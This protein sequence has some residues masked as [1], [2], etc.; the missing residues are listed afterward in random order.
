MA[1]R[2]DEEIIE[3]QSPSGVQIAFEIYEDDWEVKIKVSIT[4]RCTD[5]FGFV[6]LF[7]VSFFV[8]ITKRCTDCFLM[9]FAG[10]GFGAFQSPSGVQI[11]FKPIIPSAYTHPFQSPNGVQI[12]FA[13]VVEETPKI[14][15]SITKRCTD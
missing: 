9:I 1:Y 11:D 5:C 15:V 8:S 13:V 6:L 14:T 10:I 3:F 4:K 7:E 12:D 2:T